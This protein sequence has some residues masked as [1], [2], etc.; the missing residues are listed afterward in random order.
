MIA[1]GSYETTGTATSSMAG[2]LVFDSP[3]RDRAGMRAFWFVLVINDDLS[4]ECS[5]SAYVQSEAEPAPGDAARA[6]AGLLEQ[7][8]ERSLAIRNGVASKQSGRIF[9][10]NRHHYFMSCLLGHNRLLR[11]IN[12]DSGASPTVLKIGLCC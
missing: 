4:C 11:R 12:R 5:P 8:S 3:D 2:N 7:G 10:P 1:G 6:A 9:A